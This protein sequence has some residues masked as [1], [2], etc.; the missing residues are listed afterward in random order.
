MVDDPQIAS[1]ERQ[2]EFLERQTET[3]ISRLSAKSVERWVTQLSVVGKGMTPIQIALSM[4]MLLIFF[5]SAN[6]SVEPSILGAPSTVT[7]PLWY[8]DSGATHH[9][10]SDFSAFT[11]KSNYNG[12]EDVKLG[13]GSGTP[14]TQIGSA[15]YISP[16][17]NTVVRLPQLL[18]VPNV[19]PSG[20]Q[21][22]KNP[23]P[24]KD[25]EGLVVL[26][27]AELS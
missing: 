27:A 18:H 15:T 20:V 17:H 19:E 4:L 16:Y 5:A 1:L 6:E 24:L 26:A 3:L 21:A 2:I 7:D 23:N 14:I 12:T 22:L 13:N 8:P 25:V 9:L 10:T 11:T